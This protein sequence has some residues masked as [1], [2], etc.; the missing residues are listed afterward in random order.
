[1]KSR[2]AGS[3][4]EK[5]QSKP[6]QNS[7][8]KTPRTSISALVDQQC[9]ESSLTSVFL[10]PLLVRCD[11]DS[12]KSPPLKGGG[13]HVRHGCCV[14]GG[15]RRSPHPCRGRVIDKRHGRHMANLA[16]IDGRKGEVVSHGYAGSAGIRNDVGGDAAQGARRIAGEG[17]CL[18]ND[19][20]DEGRRHGSSVRSHSGGC[21]HPSAIWRSD[22]AFK[23]NPE[24]TGLCRDSR[25][26]DGRDR[27][28]RVMIAFR[29]GRSDMTK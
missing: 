25:R 3:I 7:T 11:P 21:V 19:L 10:A 29:L 28:D 4:G 20:V 17:C 13:G 27:R 15:S 14:G 16:G 12:R 2:E 5:C 24:L 6:G 1:M 18:C 8:L 26:V 23:T 22:H 9:T